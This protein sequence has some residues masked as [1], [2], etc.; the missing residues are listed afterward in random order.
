MERDNVWRGGRLAIYD[1]QLGP[2][3][4]RGDEDQ[5]TSRGFL[6]AFTNMDD[7]VA[8]TSA[9]TGFYRDPSPMPDGRLLVSYSSEAIDLSDPA[10]TP[11]SLEYSSQRSSRAAPTAALP[12]ER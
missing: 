10:A 5:I 4:P 6:H 3:V 12:L 2:E 7:A 1:R 9:S 11:R 8:S